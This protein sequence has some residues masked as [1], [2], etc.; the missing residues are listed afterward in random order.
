[1]NQK[2]SISVDRTSI[3]V[4]SKV[5]EKAKSYAKKNTMKFSN[6]VEKAL[7]RYLES[8][9][10][11]VSSEEDNCFMALANEFVD[12]ESRHKA[13]RAFENHEIVQS[14]FLGHLIK[15]GA[16]ALS[17]LGDDQDWHD[18]KCTITDQKEYGYDPKTDPEVQAMVNKMLE[19]AAKKREGKT[20]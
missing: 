9:V 18:I 12:P 5:S 8:D 14:H 2:N 20:A 11:N 15:E 17:K 1:M 6:L 3:T 16:N 7:E 10:L 13:K 19:G 4:D